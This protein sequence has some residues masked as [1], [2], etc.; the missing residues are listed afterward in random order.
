MTIFEKA[1]VHAANKIQNESTLDYG[2][3]WTDSLSNYTKSKTTLTKGCPKNAFVDLCSFGFV[4][5]VRKDENRKLSENGRKTIKA[6]E[7]LNRQDWQF[8]SKSEFWNK[9][10]GTSHQGQMDIILALKDANL[11]NL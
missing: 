7:I 1:T 6:L 10:F 9:N 4:K 2:R 5:G 11:L 3:A 8:K